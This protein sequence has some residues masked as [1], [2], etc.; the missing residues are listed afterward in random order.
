MILIGIGSNLPHPPAASPHETVAAAVAALPGIGVYVVAQS[1]WYASEPVPASDQ[2]WF[3]NG[4]AM[5]GA[6]L[7]PEALLGR[8]LALETQFGRTRGEPNAPRTLDLD[9]LDYDSRLIDT[10]TLVLPHPRLHL[11]RF[12]LEPLR[13]IAPGWRHPRFDLSAAELLDRLP[14]PDQ[15]VLRLNG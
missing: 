8:M 11:R 10:P 4:V 1:S 2:P 12:V 6:A 15:P 13:E 5:I 9:L 7:D 14:P 3:V